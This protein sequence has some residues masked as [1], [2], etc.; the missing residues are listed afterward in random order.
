MRWM[1]G[2]LGVGDGRSLGDEEG[3]MRKV[4]FVIFYALCSEIDFSKDL[5][6]AHLGGLCTIQDCGD[7]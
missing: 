1:G 2:G 7:S 3:E 4:L 5:T 6:L